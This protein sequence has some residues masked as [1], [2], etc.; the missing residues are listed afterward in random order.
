MKLK[1]NFLKN[2]SWSF[3]AVAFRALGGLSINKLFS[4]F[5]GPS[6]LTLLSHFQNL[7]ALFTLLP[8]EGVN[9]SLMKYW[10][11]PR[12]PDEERKQ[13]F[14]TAIWVTTFIFGATL[15]VLY[16][17]QKEYFFDR[18]ISAY[19]PKEFLIVFIPA[20]FLMLLSGYLNSVILALREVKA[21]AIIN[22][23]GLLLLVAVVYLGVTMGNADQALLS[24]SV[25][26]GLMFFCA[27][28]YLIKKRKA[29]N[30]G[31][32][33][34][35]GKSIKRI[36]KFLVMAIS[37]IV[38]GR[39]LDFMV[40]DYV[41]DLY[42]LERT[43]LWQAVSK[44]STSYLLVFTGTVGVV[45]YPKMSSLIHE[46]QALK[47][48]VG[49][50]M[51]F[52]AFVSLLALTVYFLN[53][54]FI[55]KLFFAPGFERAAY[56]VRYQV[57]GDFLS[58]LSYLLAYLL[59]ARVEMAKYIFA[60]FFSAAIYVIIIYSFIDFYN[61]EALTLAYMWRYIGFFVILVFLNRRLLFRS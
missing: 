19:T 7:T 11:D 20:V 12:V 47:S 8:S 37:V 3:T 39:L 14:K 13:L 31:I 9:R 34:P 36:G 29:F 50:V 51:G 44:M 24:F 59:S 48:Y 46:P 33:L 10:S 35:D 55:L 61:L 6:G 32:G 53:K 42:G 21:Y 52:V 22:I 15:A 16:F 41:I 45:Y 1:S 40:R 28:F 30:L 54:E 57:V 26:Y 56:L 38:F 60:Q 5:L 23:I 58:I 49:K 43:G 27:L 2:S 25:G 18:F 17:W 4:I